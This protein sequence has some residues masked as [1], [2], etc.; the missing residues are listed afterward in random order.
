MTF[1]PQSTQKSHA[2]DAGIKKFGTKQELVPNLERKLNFLFYFR[3]PDTITSPESVR[4]FALT[5]SMN[6]MK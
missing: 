5:V 1:T 4:K 6:L 2:S 3:R